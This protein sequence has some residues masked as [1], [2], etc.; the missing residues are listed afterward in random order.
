MNASDRDQ[1]V[2]KS[3]NWLCFDEFLKS[4]RKYFDVVT[5][6]DYVPVSDV[7][8]CVQEIR[9]VSAEPVR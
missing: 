2:N 1:N 3:K 5:V 8:F 6:L 9:A 4:I 7:F